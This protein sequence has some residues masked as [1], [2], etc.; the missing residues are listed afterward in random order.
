MN[1]RK[2]VGRGGRMTGCGCCIWHVILH[3][4]GPYL[5]PLNIICKRIAREDQWWRLYQWPAEDGV[6]DTEWLMEDVRAQEWSSPRTGRILVPNLSWGTQRDAAGW[7]I[8][9]WCGLLAS[10]FFTC[11]GNSLGKSCY[12]LTGSCAPSSYCFLQSKFKI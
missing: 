10:F 11:N 7:L 1:R 3:L 6:M 12:K 9:A 5:T 2:A 4:C 8:R